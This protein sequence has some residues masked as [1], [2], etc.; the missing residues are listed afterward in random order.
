MALEVQ[1]IDQLLFDSLNVT[2]GVI[3]TETSKTQLPMFCHT[4]WLHV[5]VSPID[6]ATW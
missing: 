6:Q 5:L 2:R 3:L 4:S 1:F